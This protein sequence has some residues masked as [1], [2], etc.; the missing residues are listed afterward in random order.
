MALNPAPLSSKQSAFVFLPGTHGTLCSVAP[1]ATALQPDVFLLQIRVC[2][3]VDILRYSR[4]S[5]KKN[6]V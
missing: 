1:L 4:L 2:K 3:S 6:L 5:L